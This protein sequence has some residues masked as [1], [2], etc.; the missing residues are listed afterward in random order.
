MSE[1]LINTDSAVGESAI[2]YRNWKMYERYSH[3]DLKKMALPQVIVEVQ[4]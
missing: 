3:S 2:V 1:E 4:C